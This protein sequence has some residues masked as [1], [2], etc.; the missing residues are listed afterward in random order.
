LG[1]QSL[2]LFACLLITACSPRIDDPYKPL[3]SR[4]NGDVTIGPTCPVVQ[5]NNPCL[6][7][8]YQAT[9]TVLTANGQSKVMRLQTDVNGY[10]QIMLAPGQYILHPESPNI[11]PRAVNIP[12]TVEAHQLT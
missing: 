7:K 8:P 6:D 3:Y 4:I 11:M 2:F 12:F 5:V 9:L 1:F 10:F